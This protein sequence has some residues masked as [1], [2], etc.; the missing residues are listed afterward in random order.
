M[1]DVRDSSLQAQLKA[2]VEVLQLSASVLLPNS[3]QEL[4]GSI[5]EAAATI[6]GARAGSIALIRGGE[7]LE[8]VTAYGVGEAEIVGRVLPIDRGIAGFVALTGQALAIS[9][10][11]QDP[12][13]DREFAASTGYVPTS[14]LAAPLERDGA[15]VGVMEVLDKVDAPGFAMHD[16]EL[17]GIFGRQAAIAIQQAEMLEKLDLLLRDGLAGLAGE[18]PGLRVD[19]ILA[20]L[21]DQDPQRGDH[22]KFRMLVQHIARLYSA[23]ESERQACLGVLE[24][25]TRYLDQRP[26]IG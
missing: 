16:L 1:S 19:E 6:F 23:G 7:S 25:L 18:M 12:R 21:A 8:F 22:H 20:A 4:L 14:I 17:I 13:F 2:L 10:V 24:V 26:G 9:D 15:V 5:V 11:E 3:T